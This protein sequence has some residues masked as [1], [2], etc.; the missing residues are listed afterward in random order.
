MNSSGRWAVGSGQFSKTEVE[1]S[2]FSVGL[3]LKAAVLNVLIVKAAVLKVLILKDAVL[4]VPYRGD[5]LKY[6]MTKTHT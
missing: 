2:A 5:D 4:K 3:Y 6:L 1:F